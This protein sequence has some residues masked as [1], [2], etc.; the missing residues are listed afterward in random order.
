[1]SQTFDCVKLKD[2]AQQRRA[3]EL[4]G[5]SEAEILQH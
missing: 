4:A 2:E 5:L 3:T 1:M